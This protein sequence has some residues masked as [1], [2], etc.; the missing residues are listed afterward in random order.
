MGA[1]ASPPPVWFFASVIFADPAA[2]S[3]V[4]DALADLVGPI[5]E[6]TEVFP[7]RQS[8]YYRPEMGGGLGRYLLLFEPLLDRATLAEVKL[9][10]NAIEQALSREGRRTVNVDPGYLALE[11][12]VLATT[13][14]YSHRIYL[15]RGIF[16]DL[17]LL[18][19]N[20]SYRAMKWTYPD[21]GGDRLVA[22]LNGWRERY[23]RF[24]RCQRA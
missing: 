18:F 8:D 9:G 2:L 15:G 11:H 22:L 1:I 14:G 21:Y 13:K 12:V 4:D 20:G 5:A 24:L 17:T 6:R 16:A 10:T 3:G 23:K 7:F 19:E